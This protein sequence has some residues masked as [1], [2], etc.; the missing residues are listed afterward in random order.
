VL[1]K[2]FITK[3]GDIVAEVVILGAGPTGLSTAYH[4]EKRGFFDYKIF[5][6]DTTPGGLLKTVNEDGF[7]FD[8]TGHLI[9]VSNSYFYDFLDSVAN[10]N[11]FS[12]NE[13]NSAIFSKNVLTAYPFQINL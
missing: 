6:K 8:Y 1:P 11:N 10:I 5:E 13:R 9:H 7:S 3:K 12:S 4:L 2:K